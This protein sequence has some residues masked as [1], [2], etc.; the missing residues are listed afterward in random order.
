M[1]DLGPVIQSICTGRGSESACSI[2]EPSGVSW[3]HDFKDESGQRRFLAGEGVCWALVWGSGRRL[4]FGVRLEDVGVWK[5]SGS[6][7]GRAFYLGVV[8]VVRSLSVTAG[9]SSLDG[10]CSWASGVWSSAAVGFCS[11]LLPAI[12][13]VCPVECVVM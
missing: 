10:F 1:Q 2:F 4:W 8:V 9:L 6:L 3:S 12:G 7:R 11:F 13:L 5:G